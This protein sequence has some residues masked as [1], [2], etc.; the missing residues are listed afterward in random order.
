MVKGFICENDILDWGNGTEENLH[1]VLES[2][3]LYLYNL[4]KFY[5][6]IFTLISG[7]SLDEIKSAE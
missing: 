5:K 6:G 4:R 2:D 1:F 3:R 7:A